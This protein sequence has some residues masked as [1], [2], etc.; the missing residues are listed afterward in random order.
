MATVRIKEESHAILQHLAAASGQSMLSILEKAIE[1]YR[2]N[3]FL[4]QANQAFAALRN[5]ADAWNEEQK[6]RG[7]WNTT[8]S[9]GL[10]KI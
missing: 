10:E 6:E 9:D 2:R 3:V 8:L 5:D 4:E 1:D 7:T